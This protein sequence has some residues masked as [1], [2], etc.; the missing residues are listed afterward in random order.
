MNSTKKSQTRRT[1]SY[2][3]QRQSPETRGLN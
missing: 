2:W 1:K 3:S